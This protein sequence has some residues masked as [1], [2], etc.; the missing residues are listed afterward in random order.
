MEVRNNWPNLP[1]VLITGYNSAAK[2]M[3]AYS[4]KDADFLE[5]PFELATVEALVRSK[6]NRAAS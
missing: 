4:I 2:E 3:A 1:V 6:L 5:K